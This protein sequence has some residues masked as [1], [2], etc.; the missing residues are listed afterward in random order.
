MSYFV[1]VSKV[2][3]MDS[4]VRLSGR[5]GQRSLLLYVLRPDI[6][7]GPRSCSIV[8]SP[9]TSSGFH[10]GLDEDLDMFVFTGN[11]V[12]GTGSINSPN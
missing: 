2:V 10:T 11:L 5:T 1:F 8:P 4:Y 3:L 9:T 6:V 7:P 12:V